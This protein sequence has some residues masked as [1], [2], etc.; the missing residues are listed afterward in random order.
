MSK[1]KSCNW[2]EPR[3]KNGERLESGECHYE[4]PLKGW[5]EVYGIDKACK[6]FKSKPQEPLSGCLCS[7]CQETCEHRQEWNVSN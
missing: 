1:C 5:P 3:E 2:F 7:R 6:F 4:P